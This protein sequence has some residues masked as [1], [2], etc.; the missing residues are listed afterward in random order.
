MSA[1]TPFPYPPLRLALLVWGLAAAL[2]FIAFFHRVTPA[3]LTG[4][5]MQEFG[6][7]AA[8]LGH[9]SAFYF[10]SYVWLQIPFGLLLDRWG[11]RRVLCAGALLAAVGAAAFAAAPGFALAAT[12]RLLIGAGVGVAFVAM[13]KLAAHW[14]APG[15]Y[16]LLSGFA[17][18]TGMLGAVTAGAPLRL[19]SEHLGWRPALYAVALVSLLLA[20]AIWQVVRDDPAERG[21]RSHLTLSPG[22]VRQ[23]V[24]AGLRVVAGYR[25][26]WLIFFL[27]G[28]F[29][30]PMLTFAG[31]WGIPF[32]TTHYGLGT[33]QA[34]LTTSAMLLAWG[35]AGTLF[36]AL[37][38]RLGAR[39]PVYAAGLVCATLVWAVVWLVPGLPLPLLLGL[40]LLAGT[41]SGCVVISFAFAK[42]SAPAHLAGTTGG[43]TNMGNMMGGMLMQ[44]AVGWML[45]RLWQGELNGAV[46]VYDFAAYRAGFTL[47]LGWLLAGWV[48]LALTRETHCRPLEAGPR[49]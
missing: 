12:G 16:A 27:C 48:L 15:R 3:V 28:G 9:L 42:E 41:A 44:P 14:F 43:I 40:L 4:E 34:A 33:A 21:L 19:L 32:L 47:M 10:Y 5:L 31:L 23:S 13:L 37:S 26:V 49:S 20:V 18:F 46:R 29:T 7:G 30:G 1:A 38:D 17:L 6:L 35:A 45:D 22:A 11:A 24:W 39:K 8:A 25:N 36:G 2:Y